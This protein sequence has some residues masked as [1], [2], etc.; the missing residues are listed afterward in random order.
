MKNWL[1]MVNPDN[2]SDGYVSGSGFEEGIIML[3]IGFAIGIL[4][5]LLIFA[6][7]KTFK[8]K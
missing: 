1:L 8:E 5:S 2:I 6:I 3:L 4:F 7:V